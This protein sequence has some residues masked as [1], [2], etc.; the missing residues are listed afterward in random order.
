MNTIR[1]GERS[2]RPL[3]A[4]TAP[5]AQ[6]QIE[7]RLAQLPGWEYRDGA[8]SKTFAFGRYADTIA[9]VNGVATIAQHE[10]HHPEM[11]VGYDRCRVAYCT[12]SIG[13]ISENDFIC[14]ARIEAL[15]RI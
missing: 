7:A 6:V 12:H 2:C 9:F 14:A 8:I 5:L 1:L 11:L 4:G 13:G 10:D 15:C 3:P